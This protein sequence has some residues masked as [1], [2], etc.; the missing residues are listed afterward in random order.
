MKDKRIV[1]HNSIHCK[2]QV[3]FFCEQYEW[4]YIR[5]TKKQTMKKFSILMFAAFSSIYACKKDTTSVATKS[6]PTNELVNAK[7]IPQDYEGEIVL[8][9][10]KQNPY[11]VEN[12]V[13]AATALQ[14]Q[15]Y[16]TL[17]PNQ[18][19]TTHYYVKFSPADSNQY[20]QLCTDTGLKL[21]DYP[22]DYEISQ[23]GNRYHDPSLPPSTPTFQ[24]DAVKTNFVFPQGIAYQILAE[25]YIPEEDSRI[26]DE[27]PEH[28]P[29]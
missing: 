9:A 4:V 14:Q 6:N 19:S 20:E 15:S 3:C 2:I 26:N 29:I 7:M 13:A 21:Y 22:L 23:A 1:K 28:E 17:L 18:I 5:G 10:Q 27:T 24:Y 8:G 25:L 16:T 11:T 12:M